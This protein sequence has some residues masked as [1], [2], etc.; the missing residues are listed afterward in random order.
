MRGEWEAE[1][2]KRR[3]E[4]VGTILRAPM[5]DK[6]RDARLRTGFVD[7]V[8]GGFGGVAEAREAGGGDDVADARFSRLRPKAKADFLRARAGRAQER[9]EGRSQVKSM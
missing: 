6:R 9:G 7:D 2:G 4:I 5:A 1:N 8:E 3:T